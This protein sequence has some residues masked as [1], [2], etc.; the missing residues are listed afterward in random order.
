MTPELSHYLA[1][2]AN[3]AKLADSEEP[4]VIGELKAHIEDRLEEL[5]GSG[6]SEEE[7]IRAC[8]RQMGDTRAVARQIYE[9]YS[10]GS[11]TQVLLASLPHLLFGALFVLDWWRYPGWLTVVLLVFLAITAYAWWHG[12]PAWIFSWLGY[13]M[14]P[15]LS[16]GV[17]LLYLPAGWWSLLMVPVYLLLALWWLFHIFI[18]T[19]K[20]D[21]LFCSLALLPLPIIAGWFL[22]VSDDGKLTSL[23]MERTT[24]FAPWIGMSFIA[25]AATIAAFIRLRQRWL[26]V[27]LMAASGLSTLTLV[28]YYSTG[29]LNTP[30]FFGLALVMWGVFLLP[31]LLERFL[32]RNV[33]VDWDSNHASR[34]KAGK[35]T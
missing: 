20:R 23:S 27:G 30:T 5:T 3:G 14:L 17:A 32:Q 26:R 24:E 28:V 15:V 10:Q 13:T 9:A 35:A 1:R 34:L 4:E 11:W 7:A 29:G 21:W 6:L 16:V 18:Q 25:L 33:K 19:S 22:A 2:I 12:K 8:L 31:P